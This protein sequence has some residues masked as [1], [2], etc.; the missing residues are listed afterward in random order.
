MAAETKKEEV[1]PTIVRFDIKLLRAKLDEI[2][3]YQEGFAGKEG[4]N[5]YIWITNN[6]VPLEQRLSKGET[7]PELVKAINELPKVEPRIISPKK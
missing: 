5:P 2:K 6:I 7:S 4:M 1:K 3:K